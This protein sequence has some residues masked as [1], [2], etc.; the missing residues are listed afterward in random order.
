[1]RCLHRIL[2]ITWQDKVQNNDIMSRDGIPSM[3]TLLHQHCLHWLGHIHRMED[4]CILKDLLYGELT[5][6]ARCR[7]H[8]KPH[9]KGICKHDMKTCNIKTES[10]E[11]LADNRILWMQE[12]SQGLKKWKSAIQEKNDERW[13][14]R[15]PSQQQDH[16]NPHQASVFTCQGC[17][18]DCKSRI[19]LYSHTR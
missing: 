15:T 13:S 6:G 11:A 12:V 7:G 17:S 19:G 2:G 9:F 18:Q 4:G 1:M 10:W 14:R 8:P 5:T 16:P 3:F